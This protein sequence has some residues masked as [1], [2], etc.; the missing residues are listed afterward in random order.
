[1]LAGCVW[2]HRLCQAHGPLPAAG[3]HSLAATLCSKRII[4]LRTKACCP[5]CCRCWCGRCSSWCEGCQSTCACFPLACGCRVMGCHPT[6]TPKKYKTKKY[7]K[8]A[9]WPCSLCCSLS[10]LLAP[11]AFAASK[12]CS[13]R[14]LCADTWGRVQIAGWYAACAAGWHAWCTGLARRI[15]RGC[16]RLKDLGFGWG[17]AAMQSQPYHATALPVQWMFC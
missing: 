1:M 14:C 16:W 10:F 3:L 4:R 17:G 5:R 8:R 13:H 9:G 6:K 2:P 15:L 12:V 7:K 11:V